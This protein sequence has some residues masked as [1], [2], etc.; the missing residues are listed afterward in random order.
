MQADFDKHASQEY[1]P[2]PVLLDMKRC[3]EAVRSSIR[4]VTYIC[5]LQQQAGD[6]ESGKPCRRELSAKSQP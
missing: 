4:H 2:S 5:A 1:L 3:D 6:V